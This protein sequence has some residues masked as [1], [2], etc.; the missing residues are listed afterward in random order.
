MTLLQGIMRISP[1]SLL[2]PFLTMEET[3]N[4]GGVE[5]RECHRAPHD[6]LGAANNHLRLDGIRVEVVAGQDDH[7]A[8]P[9]LDGPH[10]FLTIGRITHLRYIHINNRV[11][12]GKEKKTK[13]TY[14]I[15]QTLFG[16]YPSAKHLRQP[17]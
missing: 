16:M 4:L 6:D 5:G 12:W 7:G 14:S 9:S 8:I 2:A 11:E 3:I 15:H 1:P 13:P 17:G 10:D